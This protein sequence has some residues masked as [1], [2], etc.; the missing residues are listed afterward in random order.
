MRRQYASVDDFGECF[1]LTLL[2]Q[3]RKAYTLKPYRLGSSDEKLSICVCH[4][5]TLLRSVCCLVSARHSLLLGAS[6]G[7]VYLIIRD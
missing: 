2:W 3:K 5:N 4:Y 6:T 1:L 7:L